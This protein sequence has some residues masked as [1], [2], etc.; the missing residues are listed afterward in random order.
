MDE[1]DGRRDYRNRLLIYALLALLVGAGLLF[2]AALGS[3]LTHEAQTAYDL[4]QSL[5][6]GPY[7]M[8][9]ADYRDPEGDRQLAAVLA[10][11]L[12]RQGHVVVASLSAETAIR[13]DRSV[14]AALAQARLAYGRHA[15]H[16][17]VRPPGGLEYANSCAASFVVAAGGLDHA[18]EDLNLMPLAHAF[19]YLDHADLL[20]MVVDGSGLPPSQA[21]RLA[22]F[23]GV[24]SL[25]AATGQAATE[26]GSLAAE[27][28]LDAALPGGRSTA[29]FELLGSGRSGAARH[30]TALTLGTLFILGLIIWAYISGV[31]GRRRSGLYGG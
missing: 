21:A 9:I 4:I 27:G 29:D 25:V 13:V 24:R 12:R 8:V 17:G 6:P 1:G 23:Y 16:L 18:G 20:V 2:P 26:A 30:L 19:R 11:V 14:R 3:H 10:Q 7:A 31:F 22:S 28:R 15:I 5:Q